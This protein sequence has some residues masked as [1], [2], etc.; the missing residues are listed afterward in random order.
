MQRSTAKHWLNSKGL[1][2]EWAEEL[3]KPGNHDR[4]LTET[5]DLNLWEF[6]DSGPTVREPP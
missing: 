6:M 5:A 3:N 4:E 2:E 1:A